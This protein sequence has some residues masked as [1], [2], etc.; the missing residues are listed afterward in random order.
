[1]TSKPEFNGSLEHAEVMFD[2]LVGVEGRYQVYTTNRELLTIRLALPPHRR[3]AF[4]AGQTF[5]SVG[6]RDAGTM[7]WYWVDELE[8]SLVD[9]MS[10]DC[11]DYLYVV[12]R[13]RGP[14]WFGCNAQRMEILATTSAA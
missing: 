8:V 3:T 10:D 7:S 1:M 4:K 12:F 2:A 14:I 11:G 5:Y 9:K 13:S 6:I